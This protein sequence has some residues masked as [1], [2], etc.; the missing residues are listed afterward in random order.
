MQVVDEFNN[1]VG[2]KIE[3]IPTE[4]QKRIFDKYF[5]TAKIVY[6]L[7]I[8]IQEKAINEKGHYLYFNNLCKELLELKKSEK[9]KWL[10]NYDSSFLKEVMGDVVN[11]YNL[12]QQNYKQYKKPIY[13]TDDDKLSFPIRTDNLYIEDTRIRISTIGYVNCKNSYG[14]EIIG[15]SNPYLKNGIYIKFTDPR[16]SKKG[17]KY[18]LSFSIPKDEKHNI[19]SYNK[20]YGNPEWK[21]KPLSEPI[22]IDFGLRP[23]KWLKD[24]TGK[25]V[26]RPL[27]KKEKEKIKKLESK[28]NNQYNINKDRD[29]KTFKNRQ[30]L[31]NGISKNMQKNINK[32]NAEYDRIT[33]LRH[34]TVYNYC[35][36]LLGLKPR[37][38]VMEDLRALSFLIKKDE[39]INSIKMNRKNNLV[40]DAAIYD[41]K[42]IIENTMV[43]NGIPVIYADRNFPSSQICSNCGYIHK[44]G[45]AKYYKCPICGHEE[46]RDFNAAKNLANI[47]DYAYLE[48]PV[49]RMICPI[50][51]IKKEK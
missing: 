39:N 16:I 14:D 29:P 48:H 45:Q 33:D 41:T 1:Y 26:Q 34:E 50:I 42:K 4:D 11:A 32:L 28:I 37:A 6:N 5:N 3:L 10:Y 18:Y 27:C 8:D 17:S 44:I 13:K 12:H 36:Y 40:C 46:D 30:P 15:V 25:T 21:E 35:N 20:Y 38:I 22:G 31:E 49:K 9:Y 24:S 51:R 23:E 2:Y 7:G 19:N 47:A 43:N